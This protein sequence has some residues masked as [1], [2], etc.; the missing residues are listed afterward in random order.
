MTTAEVRRAGVSP[1]QLAARRR[2]AVAGGIDEHIPLR[3]PPG[4]AASTV[5]VVDPLSAAYLSDG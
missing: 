4:G 3:A 2:V 5:L 1:P